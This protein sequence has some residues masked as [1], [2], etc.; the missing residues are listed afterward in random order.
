MK[1]LL[2]ASWILFQVHLLRTV[3]TKRGLIAVLLA[4]LPVGI[5]LLISTV[6]RFED[7]PRIE[8]LMLVLWF[9]LIQTI[10]P[11]ISLVMASAVIAEEIEDRTITYLF[12]RPIPRSAI[13]IGRWLAVALPICVILC[14]SAW[15]SLTLLQSIEVE[16]APA[17]GWV[18]AGF[19]GQLLATV[20]MGGAVY[21]AL[22]AA[23]GALFKKPMMVGLAYTFVVEGFMANLPGS[24]QKLTVLF[25]LK[26]YLISGYPELQVGDFEQGV[27][28]T[29]LFEPAGAVQ[30]LAMIL[31]GILALGAWRF[32]RREYV[33]S[34]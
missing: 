21:S 14:L 23:A 31:L 8:D 13:L 33:L 12:T 26:S 2:R 11:L 4:A 18:P 25:Y 5:A 1:D 32:S 10:T 17:G 15:V 27:L 34:A 7:P 22:F 20:A 19:M 16:D 24:N 3:R 9:L 6:S 30:A 28:T 29:P